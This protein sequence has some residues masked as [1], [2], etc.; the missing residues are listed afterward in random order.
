MKKENQQVN[1]S[2][3]NPDKASVSASIELDSDYIEDYYGESISTF[4]LSQK[5]FIKLKPLYSKYPYSLKTS[6]GKCV[7]L[8]KGAKETITERLTFLNKSSASLSETPAG[9]VS[10][11]WIMGNEKNLPILWDSEVAMLS[12][13]IIG[14]LECT[15]EAYFDRL[16]LT[17][18]LGFDASEIIVIAIFN[19]SDTLDPV[20]LSV[21]YEATE[22]ET[23]IVYTDVT[24]YIKDIE[25]E[26]AIEGAT[27]TISKGGTKVFT[28]KS[29]ADGIVTVN[30][31]EEGETYDILTV[32]TNYIDSDK[33]YI[34]NGS[35]TVPVS[36]ESEE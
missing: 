4:G 13:N 11:N 16:Q 24:L 7:I 10:S 26:E 25:T 33:D 27:V 28:G 19:A 30:D 22:E 15:Y 23:F 8:K 20:S 35:F 17:P 12:E 1:F 3:D 21:A 32:A 36:E 18:P 9:S 31:L 6:A 34:K 2:Y 29:N 14:I 5:A